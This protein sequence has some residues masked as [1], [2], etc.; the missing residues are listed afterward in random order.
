M[1]TVGAGIRIRVGG[2]TKLVP[3]AYIDAGGQEALWWY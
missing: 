1:G 2:S 3:D